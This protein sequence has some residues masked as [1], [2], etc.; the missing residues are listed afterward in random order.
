MNF[1]PLFPFLP[2]SVVLPSIQG[3]GDTQDERQKDVR[4]LRRLPFFPSSF[5][6]I[7]RGGEEH[8]G[9]TVILPS[10][11]SWRASVFKDYIELL[12][13]SSFFS[14]RRLWLG[15]LPPL[16]L[17]SFFVLQRKESKTK[18]ISVSSISPFPSF[19]FSPPPPP[20]RRRRKRFYWRGSLSFFLLFPFPAVAQQARI[21]AIRKRNWAPC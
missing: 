19:F 18:A 13:P 14:K 15:F 12:L 10:F 11:P 3:T 17:P 6:P 4:F 5:L 1:L 2:F 16:F 8:F 20:P 21:G 9:W 7:G